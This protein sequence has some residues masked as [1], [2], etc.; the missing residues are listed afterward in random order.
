MMAALEGVGEGCSLG[1][2]NGRPLEPATGS[3][4]RGRGGSSRWTEHV[5]RPAGKTLLVGLQQKE[6]GRE[7][8]RL[9]RSGRACRHSGKHRLYSEDGRQWARG[10]SR[11]VSRACC[12]NPV[13]QLQ[14]GHHI[15]N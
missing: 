10:L 15:L 3:C 8:M 9:T 6:R 5:Q 13:T 11:A 12:L 4:A 14:D 7:T 1:V 2:V